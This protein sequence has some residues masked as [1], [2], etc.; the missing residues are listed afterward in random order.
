MGMETETPTDESQPKGGSGTYQ[1]DPDQSLSGAVVEAI[2]TNSELDALEIA[3]EFGPLYD[4]IDPSALDSLF[5]PMGTADRS[6]CCVT[7]EY[8]DYRV[9]VDQTGW[10]VLADRQ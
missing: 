8:A 1:A 4:V 3:D 10:V 9:T 5:Q 7:F 2:A 6:A